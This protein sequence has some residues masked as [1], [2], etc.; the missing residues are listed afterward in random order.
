MPS[1]FHQGKWCEAQPGTILEQSNALCHSLS[2][3]AFAAVLSMY[4][5]KENCDT[6]LKS[7]TRPMCFHISGLTV[8][9]LTVVK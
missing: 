3:P 8:S 1:L 7:P 6:K 5:T 4:S 9:Y 2:S